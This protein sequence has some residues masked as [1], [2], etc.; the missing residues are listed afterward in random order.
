MRT[1]VA[2]CLLFALTSSAECQ[3]LNMD[4]LYLDG[5]DGYVQLPDGLTDRL[6]SVTVEAWVKW[7]KFNNWSR[8]FDFGREGNAMV[9]QN[10][11]KKNTLNFRIWDRGGK[12]HGTQGKL[13]TTGAWTHVAVTAGSRGMELYVNGNHVDEDRYSGGGDVASGGRNYIGKSNWPKDKL[14]QGHI[15]EFRVWDRQRTT[16]EIRE[17]MR[18]LVNGNEE[19]LVGYWRL[20]AADGTDLPD[21]SSQG[22]SA[23]LVGG[24]R[25]V[26]VPAID[27]LLVPGEL[28]KLAE[29]HY[30]T[31]KQSLETEEFRIA[32]DGFAK[33]LTYVS[34]YKDATTLKQQAQN[35]ADNE[36]AEA[37]YSEGIAL[38]EKS[39]HRRAYDAFDRALSYVS[40]YK[41]AATLKEES[42]QK[43]K[44]RVAIYPFKSNTLRGNVELLYQNVIMNLSNFN[45]PF[46]E[47]VD[48][49]TLTRLFWSQG[50]SL[51][52][53]DPM[54]TL[55]AARASNIRAVIFGDLLS[56]TADRSRP[57]REGKQ[58]FRV[59]EQE[60]WDDNKKK[61]RKVPISS[62]TYYIVS[63]GLD[64]VGEANYK[65]IDT[66]SGAV[67]TSELLSE[68]RSDSV[69][70]AEYRGDKSYLWIE[71]T[72]YAGKNYVS[73]P[74]VE[75]RF[76]AR[77]DLK[78]QPVLESDATRALGERIAENVKGFFTGYIPDPMPEGVQLKQAS[79]QKSV[80][81]VA[82]HAQV[83]PPNASAPNSGLIPLVQLNG[84]STKDTESFQLPAGKV[85]V[86]LRT[87]GSSFTS[88][89]LKS[90][91]GIRLSGAG[92][93]LSGDGPGLNQTDTT[94]RG[95]KDGEYYFNV[96]SGVKWEVSIYK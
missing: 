20:N 39:D 36:S 42:L 7:E 89:E 67:L 43:A 71:Q 22:W 2:G 56:L 18:R 96:I 77:R 3:Q 61:K 47:F 73:A 68:R 57:Q 17:Y 85:K 41:D 76:D 40:S 92:M 13:S 93:T 11:K 53:V 69:N 33:A 16:A 9:V 88:V 37:A 65:V 48:Q 94:V 38:I 44:F 80:A 81:Q 78:D 32:V 49:A 19:G 70:Y 50:M 45:S 74:T 15:S 58:G 90:E 27:N 62:E 51:G 95:L 30:S 84:S 25:I 10:E 14:F 8:V 24:G 75:R 59:Q 29:T 83:N 72:S 86:V 12:Q 6:S 79:I 1:F 26:S 63:E 31:A 21:L 66:V 52:V 34:P 54:Q 82:T 28:E 35:L 91:E 5:R 87:W 4:V 23:T 55:N 60:Y 64:V 46:V